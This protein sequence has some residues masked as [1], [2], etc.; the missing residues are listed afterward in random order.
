M[1]SDELRKKIEPFLIMEL[2]PHE[3]KYIEHF[4]SETY[5]D[6]DEEGNEVIALCPLPDE[7]LTMEFFAL[8]GAFSNMAFW[9]EVKERGKIL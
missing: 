1:I 3:Y 7:Y 8:N 2:L 9:E 4:F 6:V 5:L